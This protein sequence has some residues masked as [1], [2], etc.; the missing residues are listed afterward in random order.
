MFLLGLHNSSSR[1][2][3]IDSASASGVL[4]HEFLSALPADEMVVNVLEVFVMLDD[5]LFLI[6][7]QFIEWMVASEWPWHKATSLN[8]VYSSQDLTI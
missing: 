7:N 4:M 3:C 1:H 2:E 6:N 5:I 8:A